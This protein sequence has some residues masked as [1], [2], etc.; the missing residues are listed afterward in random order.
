MVSRERVV[1]TSKIIQEDVIKLSS[2]YEERCSHFLPNYD[3]YYIL[4]KSI[5]SDDVS[6]GFLA[7]YLINN[8]ES[9]HVFNC[10]NK[11]NKDDQL[12]YIKYAA[13]A[14]ELALKMTVN[15]PQK[16]D[17]DNQIKM[18]YSLNTFLK[19]NPYTYMMYR[20][21]SNPHKIGSYLKKKLHP[22]NCDE[23]PNFMA[24]AL[25]IKNTIGLKYP[26]E[27]TPNEILYDYV[28]AT[29]PQVHEILDQLKSHLVDMRNKSPMIRRPNSEH[30]EIQ[31]FCRIL[32]EII[33]INKK[34]RNFKLIAEFAHFI[35][36]N[37]TGLVID[38]E[39]VKG[40]CRSNY[41]T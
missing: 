9:N 40:I 19:N 6:G 11:I 35:F 10:I 30:T 23:D 37:E 31:C 36:P 27:F 3:T 39:Y 24:K 7:Y 25:N 2:F 20:I 18:I 34:Q 12:D 4:I 38:N 15:I 28:D 17:F 33:F 5:S 16:S 1:M 21:K 29:F 32:N 26:E 41:D 22:G 14:I 8:S 13:H